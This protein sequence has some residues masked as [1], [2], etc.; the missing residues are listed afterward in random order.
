MTLH[1]LGWN[2]YWEA[3]WNSAASDGQVA[4]RVVSQH[5]GLVRIAGDFAEV[6]AEPTG[7]MFLDAEAGGD[8]PVAGD[9]VA[10]SV[11]G[12]EDR[13]TIHAVLPRRTKFSRQSAGKRTDEQ[14]VAANVDTVFV[15]TSLN[16]D[17]NPRRIERYLALAWESGAR[18]AVVLTKSDQCDDVAGALADTESVTMDVP[19]HVVSAL[20]GD[21]LDALAPYLVHGQTVAL[22]GSSGVGKS[23][24]VNRLMGNDVQKVLEIRE[25]DERGRHATTTRELFLLPGRGLVLD[26]PGMREL[27]LWDATDGLDQV[28]AEVNAIAQRC[29][30][31][32]CAHESE[33][34]C[35]VQ[36][37]LTAGTLDRERWE[38]L[39][40]LEREQQFQLRKI[41]ANARQQEQDKWKQIHRQQKALYDQ[42]R[43][44]GRDK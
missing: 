2:D 6:W 7:K 8:L 3:Q 27:Q 40:K 14:V 1:D 25:G 15:V 26:T 32:D 43:R 17:L 21:G 38:S 22:I 20:S 5:R 30:F 35:A 10:A 24:L 9:W 12:N 41:D 4:A 31:R 28:F 34:G 37:A 19:V 29:R 39:R 33:P 42:R 44:E 18:P 23:T 36:E 11:R 16:R 13:A